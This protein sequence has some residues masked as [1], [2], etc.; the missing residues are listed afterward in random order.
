MPRLVALMMILVACGDPG[1]LAPDLPDDLAAVVA[2]TIDL[3]EEELP[4]HRECLGG[5]TIA[6]AWELDDRAEYRL[7]ER[8]IVLRVPATAPSLR[9]SLVHEIAHHL[10][11]TCQQEGLRE[12]F[13]AAQGLAVESPWFEGDTWEATPSEQFATAVATLVTGVPD[14]LRPI[15]FTSEAMTVVEEWANGVTRD[16]AEQQ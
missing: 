5:L 9:H 13:L 7:E 8:R 1:V 6:H 12:A 4:A 11:L 10:D 16:G 15:T 14:S 2:E 3:V